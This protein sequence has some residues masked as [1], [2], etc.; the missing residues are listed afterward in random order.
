MDTSSGLGEPVMRI[1]MAYWMLGVAAGYLALGTLFAV[2]FLA[3]GVARIDPGARG[4]PL[5][6]R[7][8]ILPGVVALW[9]LLARRWISGAAYPPEERTAHRLRAR[10]SGGSR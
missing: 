2:P 7:L 9:P 4:A 5:G 10:A 3:R 8:A 6:F 1:V